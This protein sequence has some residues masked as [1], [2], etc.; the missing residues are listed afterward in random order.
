MTALEKLLA[1]FSLVCHR[2]DADHSRLALSNGHSLTVSA[3]RSAG[4]LML[5]ADTGVRPAAGQLVPF[6]QRSCEFP[7]GLKLALC[8]SPTLHLRAEFPLP[9]DDAAAVRIR[10]HLDGMSAAADR[11]FH[12]VSCDAAEEQMACPAP[13][14]NGPAISGS[15]VELLRDSGWQ[16]HERPT[17]ALLVDLET[18]SRFL[19]A[20]VERCGAGVRFRAMLL[21]REAAGEAAQQTLCL[22]LLE[23]NAALRYARAYLERNG[24][25]IAAG[26]EVRIGGRPS[27]EEAGHALAAL[28]VAARLC[29]REIELFKDGA[30][31]GIYRSA[32]PVSDHSEKGA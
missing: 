7:A 22:Y 19:Q 20:A 13:E 3:R 2:L 32:R 15:L 14:G 17:G 21:D 6:A 31:A 18:G 25:G 28:S 11:L 4:F 12:W 23:A 24:E 5:D 10:E 29:A 16:Y 30:V 8:G 9:E 26:F 1:P 27:A